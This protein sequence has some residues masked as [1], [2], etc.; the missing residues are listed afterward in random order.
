MKEKAETQL[1]DLRK[2]ETNAKH[3]F[4]MLTSNLEAQKGQDTKDMASE[5]ANKAEAEEGKAT[6][7]GDLETTAKTLAESGKELETTQGA[8]MTTA[9]DHDAT[10]AGRKEELATIAQAKKILM[11]TSAGAVSQTYSLLQVGWPAG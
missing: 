9:S 10:V 6:A 11:D 3:N 4:A 5:K 2:A 7:E 8:C 1:S